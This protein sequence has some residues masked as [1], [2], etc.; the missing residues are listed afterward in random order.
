MTDRER[1]KTATGRKR[2]LV[3]E[4]DE[5]LRGLV[6]DILTQKGM[7]VS[8]AGNG[9][10]ALASLMEGRFDAAVLDVVM[11]GMSGIAVLEELKR[12][13]NKTPVLVTSGHV[14][15]LD[16]QHFMTMGAT[17]VLRKP[18]GLEELAQA[19]ETLLP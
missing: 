8:T 17:M 2:V 10:Q 15:F 19:V 7:Q 18:F 4:D 11:P 14:G 9:A 5:D 1:D 16:E 13:G 12:S 6:T 3:A